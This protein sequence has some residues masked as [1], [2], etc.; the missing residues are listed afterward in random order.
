[1]KK[2]L[3][4]LVLCLALGSFCAGCGAQG[5]PENTGAVL[6]ETIPATEESTPVTAA[7]TTA[8]PETVPSTQALQ[9]DVQSIVFS[10]KGEQA[11]IS[12]GEA[13][14]EEVDWFSDDIDVAIV[15]QGTV[16]AIGPGETA[17]HME[18][19]GKKAQ[20]QVICTADEAE[21]APYLDPAIRRAPQR[22]PPQVEADVD[23]FFD[24]VVFMGD[25]TSYS[26]YKWEM[27]NDTLGDAEFLTR[28]SV[29]IHSLVSGARKYFHQGVEKRP[30]DAIRDIGRKKLFIM[31]GV[32]DVPR[33]GKEETLSLLDQLLTNILEK[34]PDLEIYLQSLT[35]IRLRDQGEP[36]F[37]NEEFDQYNAALEAYALEHGH[38]YVSVAPYFKTNEN[39]MVQEYSYDKVHANEAGNAV[40][41]QVIRQYAAVEMNGEKE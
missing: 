40:W 13:P 21:P 3:A 2:G 39:A 30:E 16:Y 18:Y 7:E 31:L 17:I 11:V 8:V 28:G 27:L 25:S 20:V 19:C 14:P 10:H 4:P 34:S 23:S 15:Y 41:A 24:D 38:H 29:S 12:A 1:M 6:M 37:T 5:V 22:K 33:I 9:T 26:L 36:Y 32:N 35:P